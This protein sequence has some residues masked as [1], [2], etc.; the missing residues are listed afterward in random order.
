WKFE[1]RRIIWRIP[2]YWVNRRQAVQHDKWHRD[3]E[4]LRDESDGIEGF[5]IDKISRQQPLT[6]FTDLSLWMGRP[7]GGIPPQRFLAD[8]VLLTSLYFHDKQELEE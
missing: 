7:G 1:Q 8:T 4:G 5:C 2:A 3:G 6:T